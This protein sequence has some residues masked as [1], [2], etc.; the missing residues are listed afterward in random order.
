MLYFTQVA[1]SM[2]IE[3][4]MLK[5]LQVFRDGDYGYIKDEK[6]ARKYDHFLT[7]LE[8]DES[9]AF[10]DLAK[11][12]PLPSHPTMG[13]YNPETDQNEMPE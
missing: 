6:L 13:L 9:L 3:G 11:Q 7:M 5:V 4:S 12:C 8:N 2:G 1:A 10:P